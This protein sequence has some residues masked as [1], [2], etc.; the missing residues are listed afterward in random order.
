MNLKKYWDIQSYKNKF[1]KILEL[2]SF[3]ERLTNN[4]KVNDSLRN[5]FFKNKSL[6]WNLTIKE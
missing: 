4:K 6:G 2:T 3:C 1:L 5:Y